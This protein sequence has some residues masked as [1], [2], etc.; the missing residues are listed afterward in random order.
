[1]ASHPAK[2]YT[3]TLTLPST[4]QSAFQD[5]L[6]D[7]AF[8]DYPLSGA[9]AASE[10]PYGGKLLWVG[11]ATCVLELNGIRFLTDPNFLHKGQCQ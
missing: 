11:N 4:R 9:P 2:K 1:M 6:P 3:H 5:S 10:T 7:G 8:T